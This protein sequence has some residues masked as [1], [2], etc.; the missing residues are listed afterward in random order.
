MNLS[1]IL[2]LEYF[3][4]NLVLRKLDQENYSKKQTHRTGFWG[5]IA[6]SSEQSPSISQAALFPSKIQCWSLLT[7]SVLSISQLISSHSFKDSAHDD[8]SK[9]LSPVLTFLFGYRVTYPTAFKTH[10]HVTHHVSAWIHLLPTWPSLTILYV[11]KT[12]SHLWFITSTFHVH[13]GIKSYLFFPISVS[14]NIIFSILTV[15]TLINP[16]YPPFILAWNN[17]ITN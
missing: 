17:S 8:D 3:P 15:T 9:T 14:Q 13:L 12:W 1:L 16:I 11:S 6:R 7:C 2:A 10:K 4:E 5:W